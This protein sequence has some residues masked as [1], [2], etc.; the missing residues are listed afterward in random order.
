ML[1]LVL[2][3]AALAACD[4]G[5]EPPGDSAE[6]T[7]AAEDADP[8]PEPD[9][10]PDPDPAEE[11]EPE[12]AEPAEPPVLAGDAEGLARQ[13]AEAEQVIRSDGAGDAQIATAAHVQQAAARHL[14]R[15]PGLRDQVLPLVPEALRGPVAAHV[16]AATDLGALTTPQPELP[17]WR[18]VAPPPPGQ[19]LA[20]YREAQEAFGVEWEYLAAIH[21]VETR[22]G[23]IQGTSS[24][25]AQGPMQFM[26]G[27]WAAYG[28][29]DINNPRDAILGA[30][31]YLAANGAPA[32]MDNA[33][34]RY[35]N[36]NAYVRAIT[37]YA[38]Q[39]Q[40]DPRT[41]QGYYRWQ[42]YY[43]HVDGDRLLPVGYD[44]A[45]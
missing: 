26:P 27:T 16:E 7:E 9:P 14:A 13:I 24:A 45:T 44:G 43:R 21:M 3:A 32:T 1:I 40:A 37:T 6:V 42:V 22:M 38:G 19:L 41:F 25:G 36:S 8:P 12:R 31:R 20:H 15:S 35:N 18:I 5:G 33:L 23:R 2:C 28:E 4:D 39:M 34:F 29:G 10:D 17:A 30:G 11:I